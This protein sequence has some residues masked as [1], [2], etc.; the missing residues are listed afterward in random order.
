MK[1]RI[2]AIALSLMMVA[3]LMVPTAFAADVDYK[4]SYVVAGFP[5]GLGTIPRTGSEFGVFGGL[6]MGDVSPSDVTSAGVS[7][8]YDETTGD[9]VVTY[10]VILA[11][12]PNVSDTGR[13]YFYVAID[14][15][16]GVT[17]YSRAPGMTTSW[18]QKDTRSM[19]YFDN[20]TPVLGFDL[21]YYP[22]DTDC[23]AIPIDRQYVIGDTLRFELRISDPLAVT[24][25][26]GSGKFIDTILYPFNVL[27]ENFFVVNF[28]A[29]IWRM[30]L[31]APFFT[32]AL[33]ALALGLIVKF[34]R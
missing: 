26:P 17:V 22:A 18:T 13:I 4:S 14:A 29:S 32:L 31:V 24:Q 12:A 1:R 20:R 23:Y 30:P 11:E 27:T 7:G 33:S 15:P 9:Y 25:I 3:M 28:V 16:I 19:R 34:M 6:I 5:S 8:A 10:E 21:S 2:A